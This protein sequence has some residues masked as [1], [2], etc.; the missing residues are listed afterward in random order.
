AHYLTL[1]AKPIADVR[2]HAEVPLVLTITANGALKLC[3]IQDGHLNVLVCYLIAKKRIDLTSHNFTLRRINQR[4]IEK[5]TLLNAKLDHYPPVKAGHGSNIIN[6][7]QIL[8][9]EIG[10]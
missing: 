3:R 8:I 10:P 2:A 1:T 6:I 7:L 4:T 5:K 9:I